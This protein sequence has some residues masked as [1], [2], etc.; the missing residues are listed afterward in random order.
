MGKIIG[1]DMVKDT[2]N[3]IKVNSSIPC[4]AGNY[5]KSD[6]RKISYI[7]MHYTANEKDSAQGNAKYFSSGGRKASAHFFVDESNI[8]QTVGLKN[9]AWHCGAKNYFHPYCRNQNSAGIEMCTSGKHYVSKTTRENAAHLCAYLC[10][11]TGISAADVDSC[12]LRHFDVTH[13]NC[14]AQMV[15]QPSEW[16]EFKKRVKQ[17]L[18]GK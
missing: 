16:M 17:L 10:K 7:V 8:Y 9:I 12:V 18:A 11:M 2:I 4:N 13:K 14:P 3:K 15:E 5:Q 6:S 1:T